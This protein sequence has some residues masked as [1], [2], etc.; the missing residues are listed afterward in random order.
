MSFPDLLPDA[1]EFFTFEFAARLAAGETISSTAWEV[2]VLEGTDPTPAN[3]LSGSPSVSGSKASHL[4]LAPAAGDV[5]YCLTCV[6]TTSLGQ[7]IALSDDFWVRDACD[8]C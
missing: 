2:T 5:H 3:R 6:A 7:D 1:K 8:G 4:I